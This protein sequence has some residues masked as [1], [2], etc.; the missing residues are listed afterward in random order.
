MLSAPTRE[1]SHPNSRAPEGVVRFRATVKT[2]PAYPPRV[3]GGRN[4]LGHGERRAAA[5]RAWRISRL[6]MPA[7]S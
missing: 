2:L 5:V 4:Q 1:E 3:D 6:G 7:T